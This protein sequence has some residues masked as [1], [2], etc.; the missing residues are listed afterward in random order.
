[1]HVIFLD[2]D[3]VLLTEAS[4]IARI[5]DFRRTRDYGSLIDPVLVARV[6]TICAMTRAKVVVSSV[7]RLPKID[8]I[9]RLLCQN[10]L[11]EAPIGATPSIQSGHLGTEIQMWLNGNPNITREDI[12]I[13]DD[14]SD[15]DPFMDRLILIDP[16]VGITDTDVEKAVALFHCDVNRMPSG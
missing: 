12:V 8:R 9:S 7:W 16:V 4:T 6:Q 5:S 15:I 11:Q 10:G 3:G 1:M 14:E 2:V 13:I